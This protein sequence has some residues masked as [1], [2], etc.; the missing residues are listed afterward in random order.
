MKL[1]LDTS[2]Y[3]ALMRGHMDVADRV[4]RAESIVLSTVVAGE[5]LF[6]FRAGNRLDENQRQFRRFLDN[7]YVSILPV[8]LVTAD[9]FAR[10]GASLRAK[11][12]PIPSNDI[13][14]A[15]H[16]L[17]SGAEL[18]SADEHFEAVD[19]LVWTRIPAAT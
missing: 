14:I 8:S 12:R 3:S 13:W 7:P 16:A 2:A 11:G 6:G 15:A 5:L 9:R 18:L 1:L 19:G 17:E 10:I 4:R